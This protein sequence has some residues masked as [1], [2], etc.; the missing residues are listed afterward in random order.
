MVYGYSGD[1]D[2]SASWEQVRSPS[3]H[4]MEADYTVVDGQTNFQ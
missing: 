2:N 4:Y 1:K 3:G